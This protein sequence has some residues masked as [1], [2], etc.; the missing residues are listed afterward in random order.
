MATS[1]TVTLSKESQEGLH[2]AILAYLVEK[3]FTRS[4]KAFSKEATASSGG[5]AQSLMKAWENV[6]NN[7]AQRQ[8]RRGQLG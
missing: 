6:N 4:V 3:G 5:H 8:R 2:A 7:D 1:K